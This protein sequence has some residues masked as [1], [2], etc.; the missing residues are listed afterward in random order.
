[1]V[2][3]RRAVLICSIVLASLLS[4]VSCGSD[5]DEPHANVPTET[6][7]IAS[8]SPTSSAA[9]PST[10]KT[11]A[12][13][14]PTYDV[15]EEYVI[16]ISSQEDPPTEPEVLVDFSS[17][18]VSGTVVEFLDPGWTTP[19]GERPD[20]ILGPDR[21][22]TILT[23]VVVELDGEPLMDLAGTH[24]DE[25]RIIMFIEHGTINNVTVDHNGRFYQYE[26]G[27]RVVVGLTPAS[28]SVDP[29]MPGEHVIQLVP[30]GF[31]SAW[32]PMARFILSGGQATNG[33]IRMSETELFQRIDDAAD[34]RAAQK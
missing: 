5:T 1:M 26:Q 34:E 21:G 29:M 13:R 25:L 32:F 3:H 30:D 23:P 19:D 28:D 22:G 27:D 14:L 10:T 4:L 12:E 7:E 31:E 20:I 8:P 24:S 18:V 17:F 11:F 9:E 33:P 15:D 2:S 16:D 6:V